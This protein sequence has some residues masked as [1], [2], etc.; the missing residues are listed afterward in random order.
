MLSL[1]LLVVLLRLINLL[2]LCRNDTF[3]LIRRYKKREE[4]WKDIDLKRFAIRNMSDA[5][6]EQL[7]LWRK[8]I[9]FEAANLMKLPSDVLHNQMTMVYRR[10]LGCCY[11]APDVWLNYAAYESQFNWKITESILNDAIQTMPN[12]VLLRLAIA[13]YYE[14]NNRLGDAKRVYEEMIDTLVSP[15]GWI[16]YQ[17]FVRRTQ[18]IKQSREIF[19][20][21]RFALLKP[22]QFIAAGWIS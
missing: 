13:D 12:C 17:Q 14:S 18:G 20:R 21:S 1:L 7:S 5:D 6:F 2:L 16:G 8:A 9:D 4:V 10:C 3:S 15:E 22:E 19:H 11:Y